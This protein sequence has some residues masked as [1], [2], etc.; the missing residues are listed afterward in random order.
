[1][2]DVPL[3]P[4]RLVLERRQRVAAQQAG[5]A[6]DSLGEDRVALVGHRRLALLAGPERL[7]DLGDLGVLEVADL[8]REALERAADDR[9]RGQ[10]RGV[11]VARDDLRADRVDGQPELIEDLRLDV[12]VELAVGPDRPGDLARRHVLGGRG[13]PLAPASSSKAQPASLSPK[14]I[15]SAWTEWVRPIIT[16]SASR[17]GAGDEHGDAGGRSRASRR[18]RRPRS[19]SASPVSTTSELVSPR[20]R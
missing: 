9:Q 18:R 13:Q 8:G 3:V 5:Q 2:A 14:V 1:M 11:A 12:G 17:P 4:E 6:G 19:W 16:V 15:G 7:H 10:E 20:W